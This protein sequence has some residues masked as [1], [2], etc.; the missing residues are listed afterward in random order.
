MRRS[1]LAAY[2]DRSCA[3]EFG[4]DVG[5][6]MRMAGAVGGGRWAAFG[7]EVLEWEGWEAA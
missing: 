5:F 7:D 1:A 2:I 4:A 6:T 3:Q